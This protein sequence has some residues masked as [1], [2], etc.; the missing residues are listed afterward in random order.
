MFWEQELLV[1]NAMHEFYIEKTQLHYNS[2]KFR[3]ALKLMGFFYYYHIKYL[4]AYIYSKLL[5]LSVHGF[6]TTS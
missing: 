6:Y 1:V 5:K 2:L 4:Y 3:Y